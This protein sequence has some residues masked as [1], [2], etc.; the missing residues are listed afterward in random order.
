MFEETEHEETSRRLREGEE[1]ARE[2]AERG[3]RSQRTGTFESAYWLFFALPLTIIY[4]SVMALVRGSTW[5]A[6]E[7]LLSALFPAP[8]DSLARYTLSMVTLLLLLP[9]GLLFAARRLATT[10]LRLL[11]NVVLLPSA[12]LLVP[13]LLFVAG[14]TLDADIVR[15]GS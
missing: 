8:G 4:F 9:G 1:A 7:S 13:V 12:V 15:L 6:Q 2:W 10:R 14:Q 11:A 3:Y 5:L